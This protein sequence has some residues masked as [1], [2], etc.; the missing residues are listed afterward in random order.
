MTTT[1][2]TEQ[3]KGRL[4]RTIDAT[5]AQLWK[6]GPLYLLIAISPGL[7]LWPLLTGTLRHIIK[8]DLSIGQRYA[9]LAAVAISVVATT[10]AYVAV[11]RRRRQS[12]PSLG[13]G[14]SVVA[15]NRWA[16]IV[17]AGPLL[18]GLHVARIEIKHAVFT[19]F[20]TA[21]VTALAM[22]FFYRLLGLKRF[23]PPEDPFV[24]ARDGRLARGVL[25]AGL[26][27]YCALLSWFSLL[28]H[29]NLA[30]TVYDLGIYD[31]LVWQTS[32][33]HFLD[34]SLIRGGNHMSAHFDPILLLL[35]PIYLL[36]PHAETLLVIQT[37]WL[38]SGALPLWLAARRRLKNE[39]MATILAFVYFLYPALH[40]VNMF[41]FH[42]VALMVPLAMWAVYLLD[43]GAM[44]RYWLVFAL[45]LATREDIS[46]LNCFIG[47]YA[48]LIGRTRTG[49][50]TIAISLVYLTGVKMFVMADSSLL[51]SADKAYSYIYFY[52]E[53]IPHEQEGARGL[54]TTLLVNPLF[55]LQVLFKE[56][57]LLFFFHLLLPMLALPF[58]AG[59]KVVLMLHG[60]L[61]LG[62]A[63]RKHL[64]SLHYQYSALLFPML[65]AALPDGVARMTD[66]ERLRTLG[67]TRA[68]V[69][70]TL[71][72]GMLTGSALVSWKRG[73]LLDN[74]S[75]V[76]GWT[77]LDRRPTP[78]MKERYAKVQEIV[79][80]IGPESKVSVS[81]EIGPHFSNRRHAYHWPAI[82]DA[83]FIILFTDVYSFSKDDERRYQRLVQRGK[84]RVLED[85]HGVILLERIGTSE[86]P[87]EFRGEY[88]ER[89]SEDAA[90]EAA[91]GQPPRKTPTAAP[92]STSPR[93]GANDDAKGEAATASP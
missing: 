14:D 83:Q 48:I 47:A 85:T 56:E 33:G 32:H 6:W 49:L 24:P 26:V 74:A 37:L 23:A 16:F 29:R 21:A 75:F 5:V 79:A 87:E 11:W 62:L 8:N 13:F 50:A 20:L 39:W 78:E 43:A 86:L 70:W 71:M 91:S 53:M 93:A 45:L 31:N 19:S 69:A 1:Q 55:A 92:K 59:R 80:R 89:P 52:E 67:L 22:V 36:Y 66:S 54:F 18:V 40:G 64:F 73:V 35:G 17:L 7:A 41:D 34:C 88:G 76:A 27:G 60:L 65:F 3:A 42:S 57:K 4:L 25:V 51:M 82:N 72:L 44:R 63:S 28:D 15:T 58:A 9:M 90:I 10:A 61:F 38:A 84:F 2:E 12:E 77:R 68:R 81:H 30:T 46:L